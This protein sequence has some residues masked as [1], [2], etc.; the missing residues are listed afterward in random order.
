MARRLPWVAAS[1]AVLLA[2][3]ALLVAAQQRSA[4]SKWRSL[5][6]H[7]Q[8]TTAG[9]LADQD[10]ELTALRKSRDD[11]QTKLDSLAATQAAGGDTAAAVAVLA[12]RA[13]RIRAELADCN[14]ALTEPRAS[15]G[16]A[17]AAAAA[18]DLL[19]ALHRFVTDR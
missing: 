1:G 13:T 9:R 7:R 19:D 16:C 8:H 17:V 12:S 2:V 11:L 10:A 4:A 5:E 18:G 6:R 15:Y 3:I 14:S